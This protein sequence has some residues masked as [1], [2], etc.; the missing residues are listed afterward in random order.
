M[1]TH[2][3]DWTAFRAFLNTVI[4]QVASSLTS[5]NYVAISPPTTKQLNSEL[6]KRLGSSKTSFIY[7]HPIESFTIVGEGA[8]E[9]VSISGNNRFRET[10]TL[11]KHLYNRVYHFHS[12]NKPYPLQL[13]EWVF[14]F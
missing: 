1:P 6:A 12:F 11:G 2:R 8:L 7:T 14:L 5:R 10:S 3:F 4:G 9:R 13:L